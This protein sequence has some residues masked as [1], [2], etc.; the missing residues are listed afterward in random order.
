MHPPLMIQ[1]CLSSHIK[2]HR[3]LR[4]KPIS[5][6]ENPEL[7][8]FKQRIFNKTWTTLA[9]RLNHRAMW[10][11]KSILQTYLASIPLENEV[12][13]TTLRDSTLHNHTPKQISDK[14]KS[15]LNTSRSRMIVGC[16][17]KISSSIELRILIIINNQ[18]AVPIPILSLICTNNLPIKATSNT[19]LRNLEVVVRGHTSREPTLSNTTIPR[20]RCIPIRT[21]LF[22]IHNS[23]IMTMVKIST[24]RPIKR[25]MK[26][27]STVLSS[28]NPEEATLSKSTGH[29][30][31]HT[32]KPAS[33]VDIRTSLRISLLNLSMG[34][35]VVA[36]TRSVQT[37]GNI[38]RLIETT[39][40]IIIK[41]S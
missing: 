3:A 39:T 21:N 13:T 32:S 6:G 19:C 10:L 26:R 5:T 12:H 33:V 29:A 8:L 22:I 9:T 15:Q 1:A 23:S 28:H 7:K 27:D 35:G 34:V 30:G 38:K 41:P 31:S 18:K 17:K 4:T 14:P 24:G 25:T 2:W 20:A 16:R 40:E 11:L 36:L 37:I